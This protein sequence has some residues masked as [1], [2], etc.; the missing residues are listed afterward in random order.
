M[1]S[2]SPEPEGRTTKETDNIHQL[3]QELIT[4]SESKDNELGDDKSTAFLG[5][6]ELD[7]LRQ[8]QNL[9]EMIRTEVKKL[10]VE[11]NEWEDS[12]L[13]NKLLREMKFLTQTSK[14]KGGVAMKLLKTEKVEQNQKL[15]ERQALDQDQ[16][17]AI[18]KILNATE[19]N[20]VGNESLDG[21][22]TQGDQN[23]W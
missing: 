5:N 7:Y 17:G 22:Y 1:R 13:R 15:Y 18:D 19:G 4:L 20:G 14:S 10:P 2:P 21:G 3:M 12:N 8:K 16:A 6:Q 11:K 9:T 23:T